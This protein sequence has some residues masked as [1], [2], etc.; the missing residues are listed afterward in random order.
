VKL[1]E[2][3]KIRRLSR[4]SSE[5]NLG[6]QQEDVFYDAYEKPLRSPR[7]ASRN[8]RS[9]LVSFGAKVGRRHEVGLSTTRSHSQA[10]E[11][12]AVLEINIAVLGNVAVGKSTFIR[13]SLDLDDDDAQT[14]PSRI[15]ALSGS[16]CMV[17]MYEMSIGEVYKGEH[18][19]L[20][21]PDRLLGTAIHGVVTLYDV[22]S[23]ASF[24]LV[25]EVLS[26]SKSC[27]T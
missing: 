2:R 17:R 15:L 5:V 12:D 26:K 25:P 19:A 8:S 14:T 4:A 18:E 6:G 13:R 22:G 24:R 11:N 10:A 16:L 20:C 1:G 23:K 27:S 9:N 3:E 21:W 7:R